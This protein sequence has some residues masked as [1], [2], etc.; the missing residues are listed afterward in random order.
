MVT[1][2]VTKVKRP[3]QGGLTPHFVRT[4]THPGRYGDG[5]GGF[6]LSLYVKLAAKG[7]ISKAWNQRLPIEAGKRETGLGAYPAIPLHLAR[8]KALENWQRVKAGED[9]LA[10][11]LPVPTVSEGFD[12]VIATLS[13]GWRTETTETAWRR[14]QRK[15]EPI[16]N[17]PVSK[18]TTADVLAIIRPISH[19]IPAD[20]RKTLGA[21]ET[22]MEWAI[23]EGH[24]TDNPVLP[25][26]TKTLGKQKPTTHHPSVPYRKLGKVLRLVKDADAQWAVKACLLFLVF[27][28]SRSQQAREATWDEI[29]FDNAAWTIPRIRMKSGLPHTVPLCSQAID[30]L[31]YVQDR[32]GSSHGLIFPPQTT[33]NHI[34][35]KE[36]SALLHSVG[37]P[38]VPHG[39]RSSF[40]NWSGRIP[41]IA[42][43]VAE[44]AMAHS[45]D[46]VV[47]AYLTDDYVEERIE[48]MQLWGDFLTAPVINATPSKKGGT[49][50]KIKSKDEPATGAEPHFDAVPGT[51]Q[52]AGTPA[53]RTTATTAGRTPKRS[54]TAGKPAP[55]NGRP[56]KGPKQ[57]TKAF[58]Q[59]GLQF[60]ETRP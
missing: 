31:I 25:S 34:Y 43:N 4:V 54:N 27:T 53:S 50:P 36:L 41:G 26:I 30:L 47:A 3:Q 52:Q 46:K 22:I 23:I 37:S 59:P 17:K 19:K 12:Q 15:C 10:T 35:A 13:K 21:L 11:R 56:P 40:R 51:D 48:L 6:G 9:I 38:A 2:V 33:A 8:R 1:K 42:Q 5:H 55:V 49:R 29:D 45:H 24:R 7:R 44:A 32:T 28:I 60:V 16:L 14:Y 57:R 20:A 18:V 58:H 39:M